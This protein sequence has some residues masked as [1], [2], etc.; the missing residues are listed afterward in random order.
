MLSRIL[1][2]ISLLFSFQALSAQR[3][4]FG[5]AYSSINAEQWNTAI[6]TYNFSRPFLTKPQPTLTHGVQVEAAYYLPAK[7]DAASGINLAY[8]LHTSLAE[9]ENL[10]AALHL[11][12]LQLGYFRQLPLLGKFPKMNIQAGV[13]IQAG[14]LFRNIN[15]EALVYD[16]A[17]AKALGIGAN[18][19]LRAAY[20]IKNK[21]K[22]NWQPYLQIGY[23]PYYYTP[24][25]EAII[26]QTTD[27]YIKSSTAITALQ[28][29]LTISKS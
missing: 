4:S 17:N 23:T 3:Y 12:L 21:G 10:T 29:G 6:Q 27:L 11:H 25:T 5:V 2:V 22:F 15:G 8:S 24:Q 16:D 9:N 14:G 7:R 19:R 20:Q 26:N 1:L 28:I 13:S 18:I